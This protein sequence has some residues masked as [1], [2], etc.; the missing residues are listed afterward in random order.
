MLID[1]EQDPKN[2]RKSQ[3]ITDPKAYD[4]RPGDHSPGLKKDGLA[5]FGVIV[6]YCTDVQ[7]M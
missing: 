4:A 6:K 1:A 2:V 5:T 7:H 3:A